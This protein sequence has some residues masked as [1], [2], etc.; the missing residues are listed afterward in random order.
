MR[1]AA[2][3]VLRSEDEEGGGHLKVWIICFRGADDFDGDQFFQ[4]YLG[5]V[6]GRC[7]PGA[8]AGETPACE[9][10]SRRFQVPTHR[11]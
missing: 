3:D 5:D 11:N 9:A 7:A 2:A 4:G 10:D 8:T 1:A 6:D